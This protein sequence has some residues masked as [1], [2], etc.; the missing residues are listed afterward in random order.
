MLQRRVHGCPAALRPPPHRLV[1][2]SCL[3]SRSPPC[4]PRS[5]P[6]GWGKGPTLS[7]KAFLAFAVDCDGLRPI[8]VAARC[9]NVG[10]VD[11]LIRLGSLP[12]GARAP[13][14]VISCTYIW[15]RHGA[16]AF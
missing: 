5:E 3:T 7:R 13:G 2:L 10:G 1:P 11:Y 12:P 8:D 16:A 15:S 6:L 14:G 9:G 4:S